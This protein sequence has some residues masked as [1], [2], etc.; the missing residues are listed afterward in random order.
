MSQPVEVRMSFQ[1]RASWQNHDECSTSTC[2]GVST[3]QVVAYTQ[4]C[5]ASVHYC[6]QPDCR[7][8]AQKKALTYFPNG[9]PVF[10]DGPEIE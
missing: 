4:L 5:A 8:A 6:G 2:N 1:P 7:K 9:T 3:Q 10:P